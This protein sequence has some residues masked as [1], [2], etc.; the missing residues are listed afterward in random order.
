VAPAESGS[1]DADAPAT[2]EFLTRG[3]ELFGRLPA[4]PARTA[5]E[6]AAALAI[7][8]ALNGARERFLRAHADAVY[9]ALT[10]ELA[11]PLRDQELLDEASR[12]FPG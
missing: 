5:D 4:R 2:G 10:D 12:R 7:A 3:E 1:F 11:K 6:Q 8:D 9:G